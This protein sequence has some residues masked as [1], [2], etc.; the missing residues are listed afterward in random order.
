[1][2]LGR[3]FRNEDVDVTHEHTFYQWDG[4]FVSKTASLSQMMATI[5]EFFE[6]FYGEKLNIGTQPASFPFT[7][8]SMEFMIERPASIGGKA[9]DWLEM[10]GC[11]MI[12]PN[13]LKMAGIDPTEYHGFAWGGGF[14]R[15]IMLKYGIEDIRHLESGRLKFL[16]EFK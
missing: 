16:K 11:G 10:L 1:V 9:G 2:T 12:H 8:P 14:D 4:V 7:E 5:R 3:T 15:L 13:V 6:S